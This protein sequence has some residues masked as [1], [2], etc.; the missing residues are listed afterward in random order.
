MA[1]TFDDGY[2]EQLSIAKWLASRGIK[3]TFFVIVGL[4][5]YMGRALLTPS[6]LRYIRSL[7][8]EIGSHTMTHIDM[9]N[10]D[11]ELIRRELVESKRMLEDML[12]ES[13][14]SFAYPFGP[15]TAVAAQIAREIYKVVRG[16]Y[17]GP[18]TGYRIFDEHCCVLA[19]NLRLSNIYEIFRLKKLDTSILYF[20]LPNLAKLD[21]ILQA[22]RVLRPR[23]LTLTEL[24]DK[25]K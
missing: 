25:I 1:I 2:K 11:A 9:V 4:R 7:G 22:L 19:Y 8:H 17:I 13:I 15:H 24:Y 14:T 10:T 12:N 21:I 18:A 5:E 6:D 16:T 23:Y 20:H 3:A